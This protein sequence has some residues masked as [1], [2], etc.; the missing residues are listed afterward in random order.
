M[1]LSMGTPK[2]LSEA[3]TICFLTAG[4]VPAGRAASRS[5]VLVTRSRS[6]AGMPAASNTWS[7]ATCPLGEAGGGDTKNVEE[8]G[9]VADVS[10]GTSGATWVS[11]SSSCTTSHP[12]TVVPQPFLSA[13]TCSVSFVWGRNRHECRAAGKGSQIDESLIGALPPPFSQG[14]PK[15][16]TGRAGAANHAYT[17][18]ARELP[19]VYT[20]FTPG[21][22]GAGGGS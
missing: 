6:S 3:S 12:S 15:G 19:T 13:I 1:I 14:R 11:A 16:P 9:G 4:S 21:S 20:M 5:R 2:A 8:S 18:A 7:N 22:P 17:A 10:D